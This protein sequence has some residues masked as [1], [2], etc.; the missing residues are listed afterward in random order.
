METTPYHMA[1][2]VDTITESI[3]QMHSH[4]PSDWPDN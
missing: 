1:T 3:A 4:G 2:H